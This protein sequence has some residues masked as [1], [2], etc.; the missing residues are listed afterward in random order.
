MDF[1]TTWKRKA[2]NTFL[3]GRLLHVTFTCKFNVT[4][5]KLA[6][7]Y[8]TLNKLESGLMFLGSQ[9]VTCTTLMT[10]IE[11]TK[12]QSCVVSTEFEPLNS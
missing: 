12:S 9:F 8:S 10:K 11:N 7:N 6:I 3:S 5:L 2:Q 1:Q 4:N